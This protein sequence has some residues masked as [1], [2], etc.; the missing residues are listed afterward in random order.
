MGNMLGDIWDR[1]GEGVEDR[2][3]QDKL[4]FSKNK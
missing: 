1:V 3:D 2:Y 4:K